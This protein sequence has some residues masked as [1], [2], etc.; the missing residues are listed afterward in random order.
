MQ[1]EPSDLPLK[2][3]TNPNVRSALPVLR[4]KA[5]PYLRRQRDTEEESE[6]AGLAEFVPVC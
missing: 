4:G 6:Q 1:E 2:Q 5:H 3:V